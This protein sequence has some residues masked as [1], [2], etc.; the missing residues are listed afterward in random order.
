MILSD[1]LFYY[2]DEDGFLFSLEEYIANGEEIV[3]FV[4]Q[5]LVVGHH[6]TAVDDQVGWFDGVFDGAGESPE[7]FPVGGNEDGV[8]A[9]HRFFGAVMVGDSL[10]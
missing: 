7:F 3:P 5:R 4:Y 9:S 6:A 10:E 2:L 1:P 8:T